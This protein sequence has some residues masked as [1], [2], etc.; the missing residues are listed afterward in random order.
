MASIPWNH[1]C[2]TAEWHESITELLSLSYNRCIYEPNAHGLK[3]GHIM[4]T[5]ALI[6]PMLHS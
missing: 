6:R 5:I 3:D 2:N 1:R 4:E